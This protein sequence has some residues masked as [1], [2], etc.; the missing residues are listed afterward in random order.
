MTI[1]ND[2]VV[3]STVAVD[4]TGSAFADSVTRFLPYYTT[5]TGF[6]P[7]PPS[8]SARYQN[9][10]EEAYTAIFTDSV[11][12]A[13]VSRDGTNVVLS[14]EV[15]ET[16]SANDIVSCSV[17]YASVLTVLEAASAADYTPWDDLIP[18]LVTE[19]FTGE[20][21]QTAPAAW[22]AS[23]LIA[24]LP[25]VSSTPFGAGQTW[26]G[27]YRSMQ[28]LA[29]SS[30]FSASDSEIITAVDQ[31]S[32]TSRLSVVETVLSS[33]V[34]DGPTAYAN[35]LNVIEVTAAADYLGW[36]QSVLTAFMPE[37]FDS[38]KFIGAA[39]WS[40]SLESYQPVLFSGQSFA[41]AAAGTTNAYWA[42]DEI[43]FRSDL[44]GTVNEVANA[45]DGLDS[46]IGAANYS[47]S[48]SELASATDILV[49][50]YADSISEVSIALGS[51]DAAN[52]V[53]ASVLESN[54]TA[55][56]TNLLID[57]VVSC[58]EAVSAFDASTAVVTAVA[59]VEESSAASDISNGTSSSVFN[60]IETTSLSDTVDVVKVA[61]GGVVEDAF[62]SDSLN[63]IANYVSGF[64]AVEATSAADQYTAADEN[65]SSVTEDVSSADT[66]N[67]HTNFVNGVSIIEAAS[68]VDNFSSTNNASASIS[69]PNSISESLDIKTEY[70]VGLTELGVALDIQSAFDQ[71]VAVSSEST[72]A[73]E[74][75]SAAVNYQE[76]TLSETALSGDDTS[77][78]LNAFGLSLETSA[79]A[80]VQDSTVNYTSG[81]SVAEIQAAIDR[82]DAS[83]ITHASINEI[84]TTSDEFT[85]VTTFVGAV[86]EATDGS[87]DLEATDYSVFLESCTAADAA[88]SNVDF[89]Y[90]F[91]VVE[92][93][94][95]DATLTVTIT[96]DVIENAFLNDTVVGGYLVLLGERANAL[97]TLTSTID[98]AVDI[99]DATSAADIINDLIFQSRTLSTIDTTRLMSIHDVLTFRD[100]VAGKG[101]KPKS[102]S[103]PFAVNTPTQDVSLFSIHDVLTGRA[104]NTGRKNVILQATD[105]APSA[106]PHH[107][108]ARSVARPVKTSKLVSIHDVLTVR[109]KIAND[110]L[111][112]TGPISASVTNQEVV[113]AGDIIAATVVA[114]ANVSEAGD[115][116]DTIPQPPECQPAVH[117]TA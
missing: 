40:T 79:G 96:S 32:A 63:G 9:P 27:Q 31:D 77:I 34:F 64:D 73:V 69:E 42:P 114:N 86:A 18:A 14:L 95:A 100:P 19:L 80:D 48:V 102:Q 105:L 29:F 87:D 115:A 113:L 92:A 59:T 52:H 55:E 47:V 37:L 39:P 91:A 33:D 54:N 88:A 67:A 93:G 97:D 43:F 5:Q 58:S 36:D 71:D 68:F 83:S 74:A 62:A 13:N 4:S 12:E 15:D 81:F 7:K 101:L 35:V 61:A 90:G 66:V 26:I 2:S 50:V 82:S 53:V 109:E 112:E 45:T 75:L 21:F 16:T 78:I 72:P 111:R 103:V 98:Y 70:D 76:T 85:S 46:G 108:V 65:A 60:V 56:Q 49:L 30:V 23:S 116:A 104:L 6:T 28:A 20:Q 10:V 107:P 51:T 117:F 17:A 24:S 110:V 44:G 84:A 22:S 38:V 57:Y 1:F 8:W 89:V 106:G 41:A 11:S 99:S 3:E 94:A 25:S